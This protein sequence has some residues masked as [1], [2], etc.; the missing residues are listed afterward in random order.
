MQGFS[1]SFLIF[2]YQVALGGLF[3][4]AATPFQ[5]LERAFYKS[6]AGVLFVIALLSL[7][8]KSQLYWESPSH[9]LAWLAG[10]EIL[11]HVSFT[12]SL[13]CYLISLWGEKQ[14]FRARSFSTA[15]LT[16]LAGLLLSAQS[17]YR[18]PAVSFETFLYPMSFL[19]S[20]FLLGSVTVGMLIGHWY[21]IDTGQSL[22]PFVRIYRF[23]LVALIVQSL[24]FIL[25]LPVLYFLG[26]N[27]S[28]V[29]LQRLWSNH[30]TLLVLRS[31]VGQIAPL[32]LA[33][34]IWRTL[35]IPHTMAATGL[36]Y[37]ALLGVFVGE[38]L[39]RQILAL[40]SLP[41]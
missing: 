22:D 14:R 5:E 8:G 24:F 29:N 17:F 27:A 18:A 36:F 38:I 34:M 41:F 33:W 26:S 37:I 40:S 3:A 4:L 6:T 15:V 20:A 25:A 21:L 9:G 28:A 12:V 1:G 16:G 7:W 30:S 23:F 35:L 2:F 13:A 39:G 11:L 31:L 19:L 10:A 32:I